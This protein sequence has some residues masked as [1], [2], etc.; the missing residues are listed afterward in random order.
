MV[1][2]ESSLHVAGLKA[3]PVIDFFLH[4]SDDVYQRWWPG[5]HFEFHPLNDVIGVGQIVYMDEMVGDRRLRYS[6]V[7]TDV[8]PD[9]IAWQFRRLV[10]LP[11]WLQL[12]IAEDDDGATVTHIIRGGW[13]GGI[14]RLID[15]LLRVYFSSRFDVMMDEHFRTEFSALPQVLESERRTRRG[16][17]VG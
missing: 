12:R 4:P 13:P 1:T 8:G 7:V 14:G 10:R 6:W 11:C 16:E 2:V 9:R 17:R 3:A 5:T 15:P